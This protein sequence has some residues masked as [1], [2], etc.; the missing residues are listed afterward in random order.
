M[1][2]LRGSLPPPVSATPE[3]LAHRD[4]AAIAQVACLLP[5]N[6][7]EVE[8]AAQYVAA[9]PCEGLSSGSRRGTGGDPRPF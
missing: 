6:A 3:D 8:L 4:R 5:A 1:H 2:S 7:D 9:F